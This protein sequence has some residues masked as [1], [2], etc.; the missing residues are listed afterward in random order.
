VPYTVSLA[1]CV[2][3][4]CEHEVLAVGYGGGEHRTY[5]TASVLSNQECSQ[6]QSVVPPVPIAETGVHIYSIAKE[7]IHAFKHSA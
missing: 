4:V 1:A 2:I 5:G 7:V 3:L 6:L